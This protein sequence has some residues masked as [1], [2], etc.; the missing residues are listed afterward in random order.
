MHV[1]IYIC[2]YI[3][4]YTYICTYMYAIY[5]YMLHIYICIYALMCSCGR[6]LTGHPKGAHPEALTSKPPTCIPD[7]FTQDPKYETPVPRNL[8]LD[9]KTLYPDHGAFETKH[10][11]FAPKHQTPKLHT[12]N[13]KHHESHNPSS[14]HRI[15]LPISFKMS[16]PPHNYQM[17]VHYFY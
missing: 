5:V 16:T 7:P 15:Y 4:I 8:K 9:S 6:G 13:T 3:Y 10:K 1:Y 11:T 14:F 17:I 12:R 2:I